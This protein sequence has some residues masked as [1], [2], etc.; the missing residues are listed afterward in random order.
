[1][2]L[3]LAQGK[4]SDSR[5]KNGRPL[6]KV[7]LNKHHVHKTTQKLENSRIATTLGKVK[8]LFTRKSE[9]NCVSEDANRFDPK[10]LVVDQLPQ[11]PRFAHELFRSPSNETPQLRSRNV[12]QSPDVGRSPNLANNLMPIVAF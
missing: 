5:K 4:I 6:Q 3:L 1:M 2:K 12:Q 11:K 7:N 10:A 9:Q 8:L